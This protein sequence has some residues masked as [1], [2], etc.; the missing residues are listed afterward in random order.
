MEVLNS[1]RAEP[2]ADKQPHQETGEVPAW[3]KK[4]VRNI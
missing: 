3:R 2:I 4:K 1:M